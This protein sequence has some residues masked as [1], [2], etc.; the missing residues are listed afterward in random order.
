MQHGVQQCA[1]CLIISHPRLHARR[2]LRA[3]SEIRFNL[4]SPCR[5][6]L[7]IGVRMQIGFRNRCAF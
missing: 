7:V 2:V 3:R 1:Q 4:Q 6:Q 5:A